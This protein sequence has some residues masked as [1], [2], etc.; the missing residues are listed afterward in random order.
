MF[1]RYCG[2]RCQLQHRAEHH[3]ADCP[4]QFAPGSHGGRDP[5]DP[6][7]NV[8]HRTRS[9]PADPVTA[10]EAAR[11]AGNVFFKEQ[12]YPEVK[13]GVKQTALCW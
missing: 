13:P 8:H 3:R 7:T 6:L 12:K 11:V 9:T 5:V 4:R 2:V 10:A 1:A